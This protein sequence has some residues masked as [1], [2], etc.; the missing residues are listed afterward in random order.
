MYQKFKKNLFIVSINFFILLIIFLLF[1]IYFIFNQSYLKQ[2]LYFIPDSNLKRNIINKICSEE[3]I[4]N[5]IECLFHLENKKNYKFKKIDQTFGASTKKY[6][7]ESGYC[8]F[9]EK[10][11]ILIFS[12]GDSFASCLNI[13]PEQTWIYNINSKIDKSHIFNYGI[14]ATGPDGY[15]NEIVKN[16][17][18][19]TKIIVYGFYEGNDFRDLI[20]PLETEKLFIKSKGFKIMGNYIIQKIDEFFLSSNFYNILRFILK[21]EINKSYDFRFN[22]NVKNKKIKFNIANSDLDE[23]LHA[24]TLVKSDKSTYYKKI[25][26][27]KLKSN[28]LK[29]NKISNKYGAEIIFIYLPSAYSAIGYKHTNF[30]VDKIKSLLFEFSEIQQQIFNEICFELNLNCYLTVDD[31]VKFNQISEIPSHLPYNM[32][33]SPAGSKYIGHKIYLNFT[34]KFSF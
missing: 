29:S 33:L 30:H 34:E 2:N 25:F 8:N 6:H 16:I 19:N 20:K 3:N 13:K 28:F 31:L 12:V 14:N 18:N 5:N 4:E 32:H 27:E 23:I 17:N 15:Y 1:E 7:S 10:K 11:E 26:K 21:S 24:E 22:A 9:G